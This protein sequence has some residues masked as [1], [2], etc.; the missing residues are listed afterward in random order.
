MSLYALAMFLETLAM[1]LYALAMSLET[2]AMCLETLAMSLET[3]RDT[4][5]GF[6]FL[7]VNGVYL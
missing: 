5:F 2:L 6:G 1:S 4:I 7:G 3:L